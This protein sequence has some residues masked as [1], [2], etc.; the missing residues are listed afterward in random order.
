MVHI[1]G[2]KSL[3]DVEVTLEPL[4]VLFGPNAA[5]KSISSMPCNC[6]PSQRSRGEA[7]G[8]V[9]GADG[10][11]P[12]PNSTLMGSNRRC[13]ATPSRRRCSATSEATGVR[14]RG[15]GGSGVRFPWPGWEVRRRRRGP[16]YWGQ[17]ATISATA[18]AK[19]P[20]LILVANVSTNCRSAFRL[21]SLFASRSSRLA[22]STSTASRRRR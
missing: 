18:A 7:A 10:V 6:C 14:V 1:K 8:P 12:N 22:S 3:A 5:G 2:Y 16:N 9:A 4:T 11:E 17:R 20:R 15:S 19:T 21:I 13:Q